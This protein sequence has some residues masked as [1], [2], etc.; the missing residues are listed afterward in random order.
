MAPVDIQ[1]RLADRLDH[2]GLVFG[3]RFDSHGQAHR[4]EGPPQALPAAN[5]DWLWIHLDLVDR[6][7][8]KWLAGIGLSPKAH[9]AFVSEDTRPHLDHGTN[10]IAGIFAEM[11]SEAARHTGGRERLLRFAIGDRYIITGRH[12]PLLDV[13]HL[14][15]RLD[16]DLRVTHPAAIFEMI[17]ETSLDRLHRDVDDM[18]KLTNRIEDMVI[19]RGGTD[20]SGEIA[21]LRR[22]AVTI[23]RELS[24]AKPV[25][26]R[27]ADF[28]PEM[29]FPPAQIK[30]SEAQLAQCEALHGDVHALQERARLLKDEVASNVASDMNTSLYIISVI[31][32]LLL[33]PSLIFGLFGINVGGLPLINNDWGFAAVVAIGIMTSLFVFMMLRR[34]P[35]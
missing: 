24:L 20:A 18:L 4:L 23:H 2:H 33:P 35:K 13:E 32:A 11:T 29:N 25:L 31:S 26:R 5:E 30:E 1:N 19:E 3:R 21:G 17:V 9:A 8:L 34:R 15:D 27:L 16:Q 28:G 7:C 14:R 6:R 12:H 10:F 22:K